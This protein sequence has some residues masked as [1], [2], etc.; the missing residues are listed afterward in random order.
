[1]MRKYVS[2][3]TTVFCINSLDERV[4]IPK[5]TDNKSLDTWT[6]THFEGMIDMNLDL[7]LPRVELRAG[8]QHS[9]PQTITRKDANPA[10]TK[11]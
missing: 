3:G 7:D 1:M 9:R 2:G 6:T 5:R 4:T 10:L 11:T 8:E